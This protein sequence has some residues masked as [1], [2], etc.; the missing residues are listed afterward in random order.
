VRQV[1]IASTCDYVSSSELHH[2]PPPLSLRRTQP[3]YFCNITM[4]RIYLTVYTDY[5]F[6]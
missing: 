2:S 5:T 6:N 1:A 3:D 4:I